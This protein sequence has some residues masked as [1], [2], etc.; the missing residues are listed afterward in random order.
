MCDPVGVLYSSHTRQAAAVRA[1]YAQLPEAKR[2]SSW[3]GIS[4]SAFRL[5]RWGIAAPFKKTPGI[6]LYLQSGPRQWPHFGIPGPQRYAIKWP[7]AFIRIPSGHEFTCSWG[8]TPDAKRVT[9]TYHAKTSI[10]M[11]PV[12]CS[13]LC[14]LPTLTVISISLLPRCGCQPA[15]FGW[16]GG[17]CGGQVCRQHLDP[18]QALQQFRV[19]STCYSSEQCCMGRL[20]PRYL[21]LIRLV[22]SPSFGLGYGVYSKSL[23]G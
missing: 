13:A 21:V 7:G 19:T 23:Y 20:G 17:S 14:V 3:A 11:H 4:S 10:K 2:A 5:Q 22:W 15:S 8:S 6:H 1:L 18:C 9:N 16:H 12:M